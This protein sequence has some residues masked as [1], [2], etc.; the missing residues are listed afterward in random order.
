MYHD[1]SIYDK[2]SQYGRSTGEL[3]QTDEEYLLKAYS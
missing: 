2:S 1:L 3:P